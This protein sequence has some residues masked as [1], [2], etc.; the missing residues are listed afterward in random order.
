[1]ANVRKYWIFSDTDKREEFETSTNTSN[2]R[3][4]LYVASNEQYICTKKKRVLTQKKHKVQF[5]HKLQFKHKVSTWAQ[6]KVE[7]WI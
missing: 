3:Y 7:M 6:L 1:M 4:S 5:K 2:F